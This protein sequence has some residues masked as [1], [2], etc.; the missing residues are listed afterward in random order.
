MK[1]LKY[2]IYYIY[3]KK[4]VRMMNEKIYTIEEISKKLKEI[5]IDQLVYQ[6]I[7]FRSYAKKQATKKFSY[8]H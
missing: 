1:L 7:L 3:I 6:V 5:L 2:M 8:R 4:D